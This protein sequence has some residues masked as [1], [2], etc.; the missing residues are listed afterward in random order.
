MIRVLLV[1]DH[2]ALRQSLA[3]A[4]NMQADI[5]VVGQAGTLAE[6]RGMSQEIDVAVLD[7]NLEDGEAVRAHLGQVAARQ[8]RQGGGGQQQQHAD[9]DR[10]LREAV[11]C[12]ASD[13]SRAGA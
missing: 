5:E 6:A 7:L 11:R 3:I 2:D 13:D 4:L 12:Q 1:D 9:V 10:S 8:Q